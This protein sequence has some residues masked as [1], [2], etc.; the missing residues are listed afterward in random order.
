MY[1]ELY[2]LNDKNIVAFD[3]FGYDQLDEM[4]YFFQEEN[5]VARLYIKRSMNE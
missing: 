3:N 5:H 1:N 2:K 4:I